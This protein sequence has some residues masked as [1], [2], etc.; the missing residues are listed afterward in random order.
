MMLYKGMI[1]R[2][3]LKAISYSGL[4]S[5]FYSRKRLKSYFLHRVISHDHPYYDYHTNLDQLSVSDF[6]RR[7]IFVMKNNRFISLEEYSDIVVNNKPVKENMVLL[8]FDDGYRCLYRN[9][10][11][12]LIK[13]QVPA[14]V[15]VTA[16]CVENQI[17][18][19]HDRLLYTLINSI[20]KNLNIHFEGFSYVTT[21]IDRQKVC[22][23]YI[24][25]SRY[26]KS[27]PDTTRL[28]FQNYLMGILSVNENAV[29]L[30][31]E[32]LTWDQLKE[33]SNSGLMA[34]GA[35]NIIQAYIKDYEE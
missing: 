11:P 10:F 29:Q 1:Q 30:A 16:N 32:M 23:A 19:P 9:A 6:E 34:I 20:G 15:F 18:P 35:H 5:V 33:M 27:V 8:T 4:Y 31:D 14:V 24:T 3:L 2:T 26:L 21:L 28:T 17:A 22:N 7:L 13:Y 25:L 12:I